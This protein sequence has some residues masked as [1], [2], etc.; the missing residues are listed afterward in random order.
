[1]SG[2]IRAA[3]PGSQ[4]VIS[5]SSGSIGSTTEISEIP[6]IPLSQL[7]PGDIDIENH[8]DVILVDRYNDETVA[9]VTSRYTQVRNAVSMSMV[10]DVPAASPST[11]SLR[12]SV[13]GP[14]TTCDLY[15]QLPQRGTD[16]YFRWYMKYET[17][18]YDHGG[19]WLG[20]YNPLRTTSF[21]GA[22]QRPTGTDRYIISWEAGQDLVT[23]TTGSMNSYNYWMD[24]KPTS[25]SN[26]DGS[27][28]WFGNYFRRNYINSPQFAFRGIIEATVITAGTWDCWEL[29]VKLNDP[30]ESSNGS[31]T[32]WRNGIPE[33]D[34]GPGTRGGWVIDKF[35]KALIGRPYEGF[36]FRSTTDLDI[37]YIWPQVYQTRNSVGQTSA[38]L[39]S[40]LVVARSYIGP[41]HPI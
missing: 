22:G 2:I 21:A 5:N 31:L 13:S 34:V 12:M 18:Y 27:S 36:R 32:I 6:T 16:L 39:W 38:V 15:R 19:M 1:M 14:T 3:G 11:R 23:T 4:L 35:T 20:G 40:H 7:Y 41:I 37:N 29:R 26:P 33:Y 17:G 28:G 8:P 10:N 9:G 30:V 25:T 24:M